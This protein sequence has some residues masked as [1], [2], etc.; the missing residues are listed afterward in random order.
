MN[1]VDMNFTAIDFETAQPNRASICQ[2]G[3]VRYEQG[4][5]T[6][7]LS[8][9][10]RPPQNSYW[11]RFTEIHGL[12][13]EDTANEPSFAE[14]WPQIRSFIAGQTVV[15][16]NGSFDFSCLSQ[17]LEL[18]GMD[19]PR[20][21]PQCTYKIYGRGLAA[22]CAEHTIEL[23]HHDALSDARACGEL[24]VQHLRRIG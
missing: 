14:V 13:W 1:Q 17:A 10:V 22:L 8:L 12:S 9:L 19:V 15:A 5:I 20:Y 16:H 2:V 3:L 11:S 4:V 21:E 24:Y 18:Y 7:E 23:N 6:H